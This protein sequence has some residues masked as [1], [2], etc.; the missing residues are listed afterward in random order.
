[1]VLYVL[2]Y[3]SFSAGP[4]GAWAALAK[5]PEGSWANSLSTRVQ[6]YQGIFRDDSGLNAVRMQCSTAAAALQ[7]QQQQQQQGVIESDP[8]NRGIW[9]SFASCPAGQFI[10]GL[11]QQVET[12]Q[13]YT[14]DD[15]AAN[16]LKALC[17][18]G[19]TEVNNN[20]SLGFGAWSA[21]VKCPA[22]S[23]VC[24][25]RVKVEQGMALDNTGMN[26]IQAECCKV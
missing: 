11:Q 9:S 13:G 21:W 14:Q 17:S 23:A 16:G 6:P 5:C 20:N 19:K 8:G 7:Q 26:D 2:Q 1:M 15:T 24:G 22:G 3:A 4:W 10:I 25:F 12:K 18:D